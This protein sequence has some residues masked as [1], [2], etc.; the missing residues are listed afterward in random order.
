MERETA[1]AVLREAVA[2]A[3]RT[4]PFRLRRHNPSQETPQAFAE[5]IV[6]VDRL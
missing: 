2:A 5:A 4:Q 1:L 6:D 3:G